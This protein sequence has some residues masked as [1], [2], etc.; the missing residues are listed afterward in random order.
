MRNW[1]V[2]D[3]VQTGRKCRSACCASIRQACSTNIRPGVR[4]TKFAKPALIFRR[5]H[6]SEAVALP[7]L[8]ARAMRSTP[9]G[10]LP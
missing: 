4:T 8:L 2:Q 1:V 5:S 3:H 10:L 9:E 6:P 7:P